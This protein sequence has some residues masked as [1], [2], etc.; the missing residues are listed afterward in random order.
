MPD[1][2]KAI[3]RRLWEEFRGDG[4]AE[5][6]DELLTADYVGHDSNDPE[7]IQGPEGAKQQ[8]SSYR[9][10]FPDMS[11]TVTEQDEDGDKV[12]SSWTVTGTHDGDLMGIPPSGKKVEVSG[13][14]TASFADGKIAE[15]S[16]QWD[17]TDMLRQI[18]ADPNAL[19]SG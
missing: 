14:T 1:D 19:Q 3:H 7:D 12:T 9:T 16:H 11:A 4:K 2:N 10:A 18:G 15:E 17:R 5:L 6:A 13:T 8:L